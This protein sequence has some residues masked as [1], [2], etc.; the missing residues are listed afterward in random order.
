MFNGM[1]FSGATADNIMQTL[2]NPDMVP[3]ADNIPGSI[4]NLNPAF[5]EKAR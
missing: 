3:N 2:S 1:G 5:Q 4:S